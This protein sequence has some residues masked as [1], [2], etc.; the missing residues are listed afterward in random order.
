M[1]VGCVKGS[2]STCSAPICTFHI[3]QLSAP[4]LP[5]LEAVSASSASTH[6]DEIERETRQGGLSRRLVF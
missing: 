6:D 2:S 1:G 5:R 4:S 3:T